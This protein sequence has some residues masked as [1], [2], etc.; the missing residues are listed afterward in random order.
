M[1]SSKASIV[2]IGT[3][4][5]KV[6]E[7]LLQ[8]EVVA[9]PTE[10]VYGLAGNAFD[11][12]AVSKIFEVKNRPTFNPLILH[13]YSLEQVKHFVKEFPPFTEE[14]ANKFWPGPLTFLLPKQELISDL[15]TAGNERVAV[16]IPNHPLTLE[17]LS[18]LD[19]PLVAPSANPYMYISPTKAEHVAKQLGG[20]IKYILDGGPCQVGVESTILGFNEETQQWELYRE[21]GITSEELTQVLGYQPRKFF[22]KKLSTETKGNAAPG[23]LKKHYSP[24][25]KVV[26]H[27]DPFLKVSFPKESLAFIGFQQRH[28]YILESNQVILS[29]KGDLVEAASNFFDA[30]RYFDQQEKIQLI[31]IPKFPDTG[32]GRA[33]NDRLIRAAAE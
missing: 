27:L 4:L 22:K 11:N 16:R 33:L 25:K 15:V 21:G 32:L 9:I 3:D 13:T 6:A 24:H 17:L 10:T 2:E 31:V 8:G 23:M 1:E 7:L 12:K 14:L 28:P 18:R 5:E 29:P 19:F 26:F 20:K 30:M